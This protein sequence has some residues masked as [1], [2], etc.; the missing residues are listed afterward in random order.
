[1]QKPTT[2]SLQVTHRQSSPSNFSPF[3]PTEKSQLLHCVFVDAY[4]SF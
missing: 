1:M 4:K 2:V 3:L